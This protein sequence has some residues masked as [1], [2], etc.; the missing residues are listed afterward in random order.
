MD[1]E[2]STGATVQPV[3]LHPQAVD[4][5]N[6][7][8]LPG[9]L[10]QVYI[11]TPVTV[12]GFTVRK[13]QAGD[14][15]TLKQRDSAIYQMVMGDKN[16]NFDMEDIIELVFMLTRP[17]SESRKYLNAGGAAAFRE[18]ALTTIAD[19]LTV[20]E[21]TTLMNAAQ[22]R[23]TTH[24]NTIVAHTAGEGKEGERFLMATEGSPKT[25]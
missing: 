18:A 20:E 8:P 25:A 2:A 6:R 10:A 11:D 24:N 9:Q 21:L 22:D 16:V 12:K 3:A 7:D 14:Y 23:L 1:N 4:R 13:F 15:C 5:A 19:V 17:P